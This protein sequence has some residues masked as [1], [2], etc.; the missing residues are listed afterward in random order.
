[1]DLEYYCFEMNLPYS[2]RLSTKE[3]IEFVFSDHQC[4]FVHLERIS[5]PNEKFEFPPTAYVPADKYGLYFK[6]KI[7]LVLTA[8]VVR[9]IWANESDE[10]QKIFPTMDEYVGLLFGNPTS[11][12]KG[13]VFAAVNYFLEIYR[14]FSR[15]WHA[16]QVMPK[17]VPH[18]VINKQE[19]GALSFLTFVAMGS[20]VMTV[21]GQEV[22]P[23][24][25]MQLLRNGLSAGVRIDPL[26]SLEADIHE[27]A[28]QG[29]FMTASILMELL[30][31]EAI[32]DHIVQFLVIR[33]KLHHDAA[34][35]VL[36]KSNGKLYGISDLVDKDDK[37]GKICLVEQL[38]GWKPYGT[39]EYDKWDGN[40]RKLRNEII[41]AGKRDIH[42]E[43]VKFGW[44]SCV[45]F[46]TLVATNFMQALSNGGVEITVNEAIRFY[47]PL[48]REIFP[49]G[50]RS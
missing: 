33:D 47:I 38:I 9:K 40:V 20:Q 26:A 12:L 2:L 49:A 25:Y 36:I 42:I 31:E 11:S 21:T 37:N 6:S 14:V 41:H 19:S 18:V 17:D 1:M 45:E 30:A 50:V 35:R 4:C 39:V 10:V 5:T 15:E 48:E 23:N 8:D 22:L 29:D 46:L 44:L 43:Q 27:K 7:L 3:N 32:K 24:E 34:K 28:T 13:F 16:T